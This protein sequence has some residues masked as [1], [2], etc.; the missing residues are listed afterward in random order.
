MCSIS[1]KFS[2]RSINL[3]FGIMLMLLTYLA[4][5]MTSFYNLNYAT[6]KYQIFRKIDVQG[7]IITHMTIGVLTLT[8]LSLSTS[9]CM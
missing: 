9:V 1:L 2:R 3:V 5:L 4:W 8:V 7:F 6:L